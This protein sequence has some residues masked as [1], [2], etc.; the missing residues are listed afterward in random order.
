MDTKKSNVIICPECKE[1]IKMNV[2]DYKINLSECKNGH[3]IENI[4][5]NE[6]EKTQII[7]LNKI[8]C[9]I[10][11][12]NKKST[13]YNNLFYKCLTCNY[14]ICPLCK[15]NHD[16]KHQIINYD[17]KFCMCEK[18]NNNYI[19]F[20]QNCKKNICTLCLDQHKIH[21]MIN[22]NHILPNMA[23]LEKKKNELKYKI[24]LINNE[25]KMLKAVLNEVIDKLNKYYKIYEDIILNYDK[26]KI[27][28]EIIC[29]L[30]QFE[31]NNIIDELDKIIKSDSIISKY[32]MLS[33]IP[34]F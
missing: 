22:F 27:N 6:F 1:N 25:A 2:K 29:N 14:D 15:F 28:Y 5:L 34:Y 17:D 19:S 20:C 23:N 33:N 7:G 11:R 21:T 10:C 32:N 3:K 8:I 18:H 31:R 26:K 24:Y 9:N 16:K 13:T 4:L 12:T 30:N